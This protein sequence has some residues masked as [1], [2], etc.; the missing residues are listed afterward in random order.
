MR[1][2][3][4]AAATADRNGAFSFVA[5]R[6]GVYDLRAE[7]AGFE[8]GYYEAIEPG[9]A[10]NSAYAITLHIGGIAESVTISGPPPPLVSFE[11]AAP[12]DSRDAGA[13]GR[14]VFDLK[15]GLVGGVK[16]IPIVIPETGKILTLTGV[17]PAPGVRVELEVK[18]Q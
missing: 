14:Q 16:P 17:L 1:R 4:S 18:P 15:Q 8:P 2:G 11:Q 9:S 10:Q 7:L 5:L 3:W 12:T 6:K 13:C